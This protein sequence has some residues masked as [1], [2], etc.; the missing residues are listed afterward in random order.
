MTGLPRVLVP[1]N[2]S[3]LE[4]Y[5]RGRSNRKDRFDRFV[6][7]KPVSE[8][9]QANR[10]VCP[11]EGLSLHFAKS[12]GSAH[13]MS[14]GVK[15]TPPSLTNPLV[16]SFPATTGTTYLITATLL[17]GSRASK[18]AAAKGSCKISSGKA[19]CAVAPD[20]RHLECCDHFEEEWFVRSACEED[21][22]GLGAAG[23]TYAGPADL[24]SSCLVGKGRK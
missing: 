17:T 14:T 16:A 22:Q 3:Q 5:P 9:E 19:T 11:L 1:V 12:R 4:L 24:P 21:R 18:P 8:L 15:W 23:Y 13:P 7:V 6:H 20:Q 2:P 10:S